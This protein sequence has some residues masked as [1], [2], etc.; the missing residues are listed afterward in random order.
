MIVNGVG[1]LV[2]SHRGAISA[3]LARAALPVPVALARTGEEMTITL[4]AGEAEPGR[5]ATVR[6]VTYEPRGRVA[7]TS[8]ENAGQTLEYVNV[9]REV[10]A[11]GMWKGQ[12]VTITL[13]AAEVLGEGTLG[14]AVLLQAEENGPGRILGAA[15]LEPGR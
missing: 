4:G 9:V 15:K 2:G 7:V 10:R 13:P 1:H 3:A 14:C 12:P 5:P 6:L 11:V 8:G